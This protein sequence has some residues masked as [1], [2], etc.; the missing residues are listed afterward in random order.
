MAMSRIF[1]P[2]CGWTTIPHYSPVDTIKEKEWAHYWGKK[3]PGYN[4]HDSAFGTFCPK[5]GKN[6]TKEEFRYFPDAEIESI[7]KLVKT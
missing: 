3:E 4:A 7:K 5:C 1:C 6:G 2:A